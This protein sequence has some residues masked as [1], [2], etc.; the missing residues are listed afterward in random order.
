MTFKDLLRARPLAAA[1]LALLLMTACASLDPEPPAGTVKPMGG[2]GTSTFVPTAKDEQ[3]RAWFRHGLQLAYA[4]EHAEAARVFRLAARNDPTCAMCE[5]G[6]AYALGPN[7]N[8]GR[9][10]SPRVIRAAIERARVAA[11]RGKATPLERGLIEAMAARHGQAEPKEQQALQA[12]GAALCGAGKSPRQASPQDLAYAA[13]MAQLLMAHPD[14][15]DVVALHADAVMNTTPWQWWDRK[16]GQPQGATADALARLLAGARQHP[17]HTGILHLLVHIAEHSPEPRQAEAAADR[18]GRIAPGAP[19]L[20][21]MGSHVYKNL[22]RFAD[23][24]RANEDAL[25]VQKTFDADI[26]A[27]G[28]TPGRNWDGHHLHFLWYSALME[29]RADL[30][31]RTADRFGRLVAGA[32]DDFGDYVRI[33]PWVT[34]VRL[35][36]WPEVL[37]QPVPVGGLGLQQGYAAMARGLALVNRGQLAKAREELVQLET[38]RALPTLKRSRWH[39]GEDTPRQMLDVAHGLLAGAIARA[40]GRFDAAVAALEKAAALD[41]A[42]GVDPPVIGAGARLALV[43]TLVAAGRADEADKA[44]AEVLRVHGPST[45]THLAQAEVARLRGASDEAARH[46]AQAQTAW[47]AA[48]QAA[49]PRL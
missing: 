2:L 38:A 8:G 25:A 11:Q 9:D 10:G 45:W 1:A 48:D 20:V 30:S 7:I 19:H 16:T 15:P 42:L 26:K 41:D 39:G 37:V 23:G 33:M 18:L 47:R 36:R 21:H 3:T 29:G 44:L 24:T 46:A 32:G 13:A 12:R 40:E 28:V 14:H 27:Q 17:D 4:F 22:G 49:L 43:G 31:L 5:W 34:L 35:Q 6:V